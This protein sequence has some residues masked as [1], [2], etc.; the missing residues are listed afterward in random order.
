M[1][2]IKTLQKELPKQLRVDDFND[3]FWEYEDGL[4]DKKT[5][6]LACLA[7]TVASLENLYN[8]G[9]INTCDIEEAF[10]NGSLKLITM[11]TDDGKDFQHLTNPAAYIAMITTNSIRD[12]FRSRMREEPTNTLDQIDIEAPELE[13][14]DL[15]DL[16]GSLAINRIDT[17]VLQMRVQKKTNREIG[18]ALGLSPSTISLRLNRL[19][20]KYQELQ[21]E[22]S[23]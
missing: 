2:A 17:T 10:S 23:E 12:L 18:E 4:I 16:I 8:L 14:I 15:V 1:S 21:K 19:Y 5:I 13:Y 9:K 3:L 20:N 11:L 7:R 22:L 6:L